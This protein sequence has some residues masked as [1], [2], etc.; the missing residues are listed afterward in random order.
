MTTWNRMVDAHLH[1]E[2]RPP[3]PA[4]KCAW[5]ESEIEEGD[6]Y[7]MYEDEPYCSESCIVSQL[8]ADDLAKPLYRG[9]EDEC[10]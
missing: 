7:Y 3:I 5:C 2:A 1:D 10:G 6:I 9:A 4:L 8:I